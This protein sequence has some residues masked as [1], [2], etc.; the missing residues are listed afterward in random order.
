M[1]SGARPQKDARWT[2]AFLFTKWSYLLIDYLQIHLHFPRLVLSVPIRISAQRSV[3]SAISTTMTTNIDVLLHNTKGTFIETK[4]TARLDFATCRTR[5]PGPI[6]KSLFSRWQ[7]VPGIP[8][9]NLSSLT[10]Y[11]S[12]ISG[13][14][15]KPPTW[16]NCVQTGRS[17]NVVAETLTSAAIGQW[18]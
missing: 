14:S 6:D 1:T 17:K 3:T 4:E 5:P 13:N 8:D 7:S 10:L 2:A 18:R 15:W 16:R 9:R 11:L 12:L